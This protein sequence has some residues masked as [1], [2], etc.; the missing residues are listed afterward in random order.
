MVVVDLRKEECGEEKE[1]EET[2]LALLYWIF[3]TFVSDVRSNGIS[4]LFP[5]YPNP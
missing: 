3:E 5:K 2:L 1:L 4:I